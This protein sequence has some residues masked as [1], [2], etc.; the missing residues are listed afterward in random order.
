M[1]ASSAPA[2]GSG[3]S[4]GDMTDAPAALNA[5]TVLTGAAVDFLE[6]MDAAGWSFATAE[7]LRDALIAYFAD[8]QAELSVM[9]SGAVGAQHR[10]AATYQEGRLSDR[11]SK[12]SRAPRPA[13][14]PHPYVAHNI[15]TDGAPAIGIDPA[16]LTDE[17]LRAQIKELEELMRDENYL[18]SQ[19]TAQQEHR[20]KKLLLESMD[21]SNAELAAMNQSWAKEDDQRRQDYEKRLETE[22]KEARQWARIN[23]A[24]RA[25]QEA[26]SIEAGRA[27]LNRLTRADLDH[28]ARTFDVAVLSWASKAQVQEQI[29]AATVG[30]RQPPAEG[31]E[32]IGRQVF[33]VAQARVA[34]KPRGERYDV[35]SALQV[36]TEDTWESAQTDAAA[37]SLRLYR[38]GF[39]RRI[40]AYLRQTNPESSDA[41]DPQVQ[42]R[43][44]PNQPPTTEHIGDHVARIDQVMAHAPL[45]T[46]V[47]VW[48]GVHKPELVWGDQWRPDG[49]M[50]GAEWTEQSYCS[51]SADHQVAKSTF[52]ADVV[53]RLHV[54]SGVGAVQLSGWRNRDRHTLEAELL[55]QRG[56]HM[57]VTADQIEY[58]DGGTTWRGDR[59]VPLPP[60]ARRV[61]DVEVTPSSPGRGDEERHRS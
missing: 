42:I 10:N 28:V 35:A 52:G 34:D 39:W 37:R 53:M 58:E 32:A 44:L 25:L 17:A 9:I 38:S 5:A 16:D 20:W 11:P 13:P 8:A 40:G 56:L 47:Q 60:V 50:T 33:A 18:L 29:L 12:V 7:P 2:A 55:L 59:E 51:T 61:L 49:D 4:G 26:V 41:I 22:L 57:R 14:R 27:A 54:P 6:A 45:Q 19:G 21:R 43:E 3:I 15:S 23:A 36:D 31:A 30:A 1:N 46:P 48:R 24:N